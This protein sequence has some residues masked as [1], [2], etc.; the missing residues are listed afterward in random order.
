MHV[1]AGPPDLKDRKATTI[2]SLVF[3]L[4]IIAHLHQHEI[5]CSTAAQD[6]STKC[7]THSHL[8]VGS[9]VL[10]KITLAL[11]PPSGLCDAKVKVAAKASDILVLSLHKKKCHAEFSR[12]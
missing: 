6:A 9:L 1:E 8:E 12:H 5:W 11:A 7:P 10:K 3:V 4:I 2:I